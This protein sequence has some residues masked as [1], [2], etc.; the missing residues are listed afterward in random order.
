MKTNLTLNGF[1]NRLVDGLVFCRKVYD[2]FDQR[3]NSPGG[4][5]KIR[6]RKGKSEKKLIEELIPIAR[7]VQTRYREGR[8]LK[9]KWID[10]GQHYDALLVSSGIFVDK[11][12]VPKLQHL[13]VTT[14]VHEHDHLRRELISQG[15]P[16]FGHK[17]IRRDKATKM[18]VSEPHVDH[19]HEILADM[20]RRI[21]TRIEAKHKIKYPSETVL[22]IQCIPYRLL[23]KQEWEEIIQQV[24]A[25]TVKCQFRE[26][27]IFDSR[28]GDSAAL[29]G[30]EH[31]SVAGVRS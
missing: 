14:V 16:V 6:L 4:V 27:L 11:G 29:C 15:Q 9:V 24:E 30:R 26:I 17:L 20:T 10:G 1:D 18:I 25:A 28:S 13:E 3:L 23:F 21:L 2:F 8:R 7:Y 22:V 5:N 12:Y 19:A 31:H